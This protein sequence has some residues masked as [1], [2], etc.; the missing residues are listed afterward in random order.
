MTGSFTLSELKAWAK[1]YLLVA[2]TAAGTENHSGKLH[3]IS[4]VQ[5]CGGR[6]RA[7]HGTVTVDQNL[8]VRGWIHPVPLQRVRE[9]LVHWVW[10]KGHREA[11]KRGKRASHVPD[12]PVPFY[13]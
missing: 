4:R 1:S 10:P 3:R 8:E 5:S 11:A 6:A 7:S 2:P 13:F 12:L 9:S